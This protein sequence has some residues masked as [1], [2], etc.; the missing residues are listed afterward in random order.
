MGTLAGDGL[1]TDLVE[2]LG[3][4][5]SLAATRWTSDDDGLGYPGCDVRPRLSNPSEVDVD[6]HGWRLAAEIEHGGHRSRPSTIR[7]RGPRQ[8]LTGDLVG[9]PLEC[10]RSDRSCLVGPGSP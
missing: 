9:E 1:D 8:L 10:Q 6:A 7:Y 5:A 3:D 4:K 2:N